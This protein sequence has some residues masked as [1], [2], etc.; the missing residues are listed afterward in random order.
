MPQNAAYEA[1]SYRIDAAAPPDVG[2]RA[3]EYY[4]AHAPVGFDYDELAAERQGMSLGQ[5]Y[6][7]RY[8]DLQA[9]DGS[10]GAAV[11]GNE[12]ARLAGASFPGQV[13]PSPPSRGGHKAPR[14]ASRPGPRLTRGRGW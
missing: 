13:Q 5:L 4:E 3:A 9:S 14:G 8:R 10:Q 1:E 6:A 2:G 12:A 11:T 7:Q